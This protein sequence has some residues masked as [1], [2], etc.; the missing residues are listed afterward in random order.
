MLDLIPSALL[1]LCAAGVAA[2][3][4][5]LTSIHFRG[6]EHLLLLLVFLP[7]AFFQELPAQLTSVGGFGVTTP[8]LVC[9]VLLARTVLRPQAAQDRPDRLR[10]GLKLS[11]ALWLFLVAFSLLRGTE[12]FGLQQ[13]VNEARPFVYVAIITVWF[14]VVFSADQATAAM[15]K[16]APFMIGVLLTVFLWHVLAN[17]LGSS[18]TVLIDSSG[19][20]VESRA[21]NSGQSF[22]LLGLSFALFFS[23]PKGI[24]Y[25]ALPAAG[26]LA[27]LLAQN[28]SVW[29]AALAAGVAVLLIS[30]STYRM[31]AV[32]SGLGALGAL[33][34]AYIASPVAR[35][36]FEQVL[37]SS[38][39]SRTYDG[40]V[41]GWIALLDQQAQSDPLDRI[42]GLAFGHGWDR[43][44]DGMF[45]VFSPHNWYVTS[46]V[47]IGYVGLVLT[48]AILVISI[49]RSMALR[50]RPEV[51]ATAVAL[52]VYFW[53]YNFDWYLAPMFAFVVV[54]VWSQPFAHESTRP[55]RRD[56][57]VHGTARSTSSKIRR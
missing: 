9:A 15:V 31:R 6:R 11:L 49:W 4:I 2:I 48:V 22:L 55:Q 23:Q 34:V 10:S 20:S 19:N 33:I 8:D 42:L 53:A 41:A 51:I 43:L 25:R 24:L 46:T 7:A 45:V 54:S 29:A 18:T 36:A 32:V 50:G 44:Q 27:V 57:N 26:F 35:G 28:R 5:Y 14:L 21:L 38:Q 12:E 37:S 17:G 30:A 52:A 3:A 13:A 47:R 39:D 56:R 40:R 16:V 1:A